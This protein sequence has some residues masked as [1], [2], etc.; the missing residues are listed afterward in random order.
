LKEE[1]GTRKEEGGRRRDEK[2]AVG[3]RWVAYNTKSMDEPIPA[4]PSRLLLR[5]SVAT[6]IRF[7]GP[8]IGL[9]GLCL[10]V[11]L[12]LVY[13]FDPFLKLFQFVYDPAKA[14]DG[15]FLFYDGL[16]YF[17]L[18]SLA[19]PLW[20]GVYGVAFAILAKSPNPATG[21]KE[22]WKRFLP[23]AVLGFFVDV[24]WLGIDFGLHKA[25]MS[26]EAAQFPSLLLYTIV[27]APIMLSLPA[28]V[29]L[30]MG[31]IQSVAYSVKRFEEAPWVYFGYLLG[32]LGIAS[33]GI[34]MCGV[35]VVFTLPV[36]AM[37]MAML[38]AGGPVQGAERPASG[39]DL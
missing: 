15:Q 39:G 17:L 11:G 19:Y 35:G 16:S 24:A 25:H 21:F 8:L 3:F 27:T 26:D 14:T 9:S 30:R 4:K 18:S 33:I 36:Y 12:G 13:A 7:A 34:L 1:G 2:I 20:A 29:G 32:A 31:V 22:A 23:V 6:V 10:L 37:A 28:I 38:V 5:V